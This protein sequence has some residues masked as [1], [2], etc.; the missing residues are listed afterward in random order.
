MSNIFEETYERIRRSLLNEESIAT[1]EDYKK[2]AA[3][4]FNKDKDGG[5]FC[6]KAYGKSIARISPQS[7]TNRWMVDCSVFERRRR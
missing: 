5:V 4:G 6:T 1:E 3:V 2:L 7:R